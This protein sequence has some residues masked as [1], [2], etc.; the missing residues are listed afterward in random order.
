VPN[1]SARSPPQ[2]LRARNDEV[3]LVMSEANGYCGLDARRQ[4]QERRLDGGKGI[5]SCL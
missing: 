5:T 3:E 4:N 2:L 1:L